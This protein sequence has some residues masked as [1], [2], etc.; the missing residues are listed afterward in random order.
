MNRVA[1]LIL[2]G[3]VLG[4]GLVWGQWVQSCPPPAVCPPPPCCP[5]SPPEPSCYDGFWL[6]EPIV[7]EVVVPVGRG[8]CCPVT[9]QI[10]GWSVQALGGAVVHGHTYAIPVSATT[11][12]LW[13]QKTSA[14]IQVGPG[15]YLITVRTSDGKALQSYV[16]IADRS[17]CRSS[18]CSRPSKPCGVPICD[19]H[20]KLS[21]LPVIGPCCDP[22]CDPCCLQPYY[23]IGGGK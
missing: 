21:A 8:C 14:G 7:I 18:L 16:R 12:I 1:L 23:I 3:L 20:L 6:G 17:Y 22:C 13:H 19:P 5:P 9:L 11:V 4:G 2:A 15:F 10:T